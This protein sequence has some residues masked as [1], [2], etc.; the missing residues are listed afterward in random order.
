MFAKAQLRRESINP[1]EVRHEPVLSG[2]PAVAPILFRGTNALTPLPP[3]PVNPAQQALWTKADTV[4]EAQRKWLHGFNKSLPSGYAVIAFPLI[5]T[6]VWWREQGEFLMHGFGFFPAS[7][8]NTALAATD[9][10]SARV[11]NLPLAPR[12]HN[13]LLEDSTHQRLGQLRQRFATE[14]ENMGLAFARGDFGGLGS[15]VGRKARYGRELIEIASSIGFATFGKQAWLTHEHH[16]YSV[17]GQ[18]KI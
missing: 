11:L 14:H 4:L 8:A 5:P 3:T 17:L 16:F 15:S 2:S 13:R 10:V 1:F 9:P 6:G 18:R 12:V 7:L